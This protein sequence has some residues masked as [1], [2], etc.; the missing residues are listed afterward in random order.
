MFEE[1]SAGMPLPTPVVVIVADRDAGVV[2]RGVLIP[3][4]P[5]TLAP[6]EMLDPLVPG[7]P[8]MTEPPRE[9]D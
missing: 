8:P 5:D 7:G 4:N 1:V 6:G 3:K 2:A 9:R